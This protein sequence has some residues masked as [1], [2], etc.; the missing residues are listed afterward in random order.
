MPTPLRITS[1]ILLAF[2]PLT[3]QAPPSSPPPGA[4][5][6]PAGR[7]GGFIP[8][9]Q[10]PAGDP[11]QI[12]RGNK[13]YSVSCRSCH[14]A[15]LRGGDMG[16]PN[17]LRSQLALSDREGEKIVPVIHGS[18]Q[19]SGMPAIPM[20]D[21]DAHAV[22]TYV[23]SVL[24]TIGSQGKPPSSLEPP[25]ILVGDASRGSTYFQ[26]KCV[27][28]HSATGDLR[29]I[30]AK[31]PDPK[32]L[33]NAWLAGGG[34]PGRGGF[35]AQPPS[36]RRTVTASVTLPSG[37]KVQGDVVRIDDFVLTLRMQDGSTRT[38]AREGNDPRVELHDPLQGHRDLLP[39]LT[40]RDMHDVTA[41]LVTLK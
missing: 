18:L 16:G 6:R 32:A 27:S 26:S 36:P 40:D 34:R 14:G 23:R 13:L 11:A 41:W 9:Q 20:S 24:A 3:G 38:I 22:A 7:V 4:A 29:G 33:Q 5:R 8:G 39:V 21:A 31:Y 37:E 28:C 30:A 15:D 25:S 10:R 12:E 2:L 35:S 19:A 1:A 17:L